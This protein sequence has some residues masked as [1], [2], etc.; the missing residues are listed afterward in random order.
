MPCRNLEESDASMR[1]RLVNSLSQS[2]PGSALSKALQCMNDDED[3]KDPLSSSCFAELRLDKEVPDEDDELTSLSWLQDSNLLKDINAGEDEDMKENGDIKLEP[4][5]AQTHPS[6]VPYNPHKHINSKPPYSFSCLIFMALEESPTKM[7]PVKDIYQWILNHFPYF[8]NAPTGW[9]NSVR[10]NLSLNKCFKKVDKDRGQVRY[11]IGK[12]SLWCVDPDYRP[13]LLQALRKTPYHPYHQLQML[14]NPPPSQHSHYP[15]YGLKP[16]PLAPRIGPNSISPHLFPF[17]S[18]RLGQSHL[19][20]DSDI[21]DVAQTLVSLKSWSKAK[22]DNAN[23]AQGLKR[24][25]GEMNSPKKIPQGPVI[26]TDNPS[27][28][29]TYSITRVEADED[30]YVPGSPGSSIDDEYDFGSDDDIDDY[31]DDELNNRVERR[32]NGDNLDSEGESGVDEVDGCISNNNNNNVRTPKRA[33]LLEHAKRH[34]FEETSEEEKKKIEEGADAL[35]NLAGICLSR[36]HTFNRAM[37]TEKLDGTKDY[38]EDIDDSSNC[39]SS[40]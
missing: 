16:Q 32:H 28:D 14:A 37:I 7:L 22:A 33:R 30:E 5:Y 3:M 6:H 36:Q 20:I 34:R 4:G 12:G 1:Q 27:E 39:S 35:L 2:F 23:F 40:S 31:S 19:D 10:H 24:K 21:K 15:L 18:R 11:T 8:Q 17:L 13:N 26:C 9:K 38:P 25:L 29:H